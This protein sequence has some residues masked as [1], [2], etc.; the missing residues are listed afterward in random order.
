VH[1]LLSVWTQGWHISQQL[2]VFPQL[3][4]MAQQMSEKLVQPELVKKI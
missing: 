1:R 3:R 2:W 4:S